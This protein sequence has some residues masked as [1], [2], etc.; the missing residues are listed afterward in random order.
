[1][2]QRL[3]TA[4]PLLSGAAAAFVLPLMPYAGICTALILCDCVTAVNLRRRMRRR[5]MLPVDAGL[6][7]SD[8]LG[9]AINTLVKVYAG[10]LLAHG[11][12]L[13]F[14]TGGWCVRFVGGAVCFRQVLSI[15]ENESSATDSTWARHARRYL[16]DKAR[17]AAR[18]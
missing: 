13:T 8:R 1:M 10:L 17:R 7:C 14:E 5:G 9:T 4:A 6:I 11:I 18:L 2:T 16:M 12:D 15:L 3:Y